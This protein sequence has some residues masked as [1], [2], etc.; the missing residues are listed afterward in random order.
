MK[1]D[2]Q[3]QLAEIKKDIQY[4]SEKVHDGFLGV[5]KRQDYTNGKVL[6]NIERIHIIDELLEKLTSS[7]LTK[8]QYDRD[9]RERMTTTITEGKEWKTYLLRSIIG[10]IIAILLIIIGYYLGQ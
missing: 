9:W 5:Y 3:V 4:L 10:F 8:A 2:D 6:N 7:S 1:M